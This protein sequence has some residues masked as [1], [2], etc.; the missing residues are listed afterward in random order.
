MLFICFLFSLKGT[1]LPSQTLTASD[2][3]GGAHRPSHLPVALL[4]ALSCFLVSSVSSFISC[5]QALPQSYSTGKKHNSTAL[6]NDSWSLLSLS[7]P[8]WLEAIHLLPRQGAGICRGQAVGLPCQAPGLTPGQVCVWAGWS[9]SQN[10]L[11]S[12]PSSCQH[13]EWRTGVAPAALHFTCWPQAA[14]RNQPPLPA[15]SLP[16]A[17][18]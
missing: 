11:L 6:I 17:S 18:Y 16:G 4:K 2:Y 12:W 10:V 7:S 14:P 5:L 1:P 3:F 15:P 13:L 8:L 9:L